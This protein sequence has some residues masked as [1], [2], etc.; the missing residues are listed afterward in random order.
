MLDLTTSNPLE[1]IAAAGKETLQDRMGLLAD[2]PDDVLMER[3]VSLRL[4]RHLAS[5]VRHQ[6]FHDS[7]IRHRAR[8]KSR[9]RNVGAGVKPRPAGV[10]SRCAC[11]WVRPR[12]PPSAPRTLAGLEPEAHFAF[13]AYAW[14]IAWWVTAPVPWTVTSFLPFVLLPLGGAMPFADVAARYGHTIPA[15]P[16]GRH[17]LR[18]EAERSG[19]VAD[20]QALKAE[21]DRLAGQLHSAKAA[22]AGAAWTARRETVQSVNAGAF[23]RPQA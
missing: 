17:A 23:Y 18:I 1:F 21:R 2:R 10:R 7:D 11:R 16:D 12:S 22:V 5:S 15:L 14:I 19:W 6:Q 20:N 13:G 9:R 3:E 4:L 8:W